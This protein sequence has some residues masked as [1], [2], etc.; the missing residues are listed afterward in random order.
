MGTKV[1]LQSL[2]KSLI[3]TNEFLVNFTNI[4]Q[5]QNKPNRN[6]Q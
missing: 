3:A 6:N 1:T 5:L 2:I 4:S